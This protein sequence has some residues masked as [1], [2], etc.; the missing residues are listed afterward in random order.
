MRMVVPTSLSAQQ[1][2]RGLITNTTSSKGT[3]RFVKDVTAPALSHRYLLATSLAL[4]AVCSALAHARDLLQELRRLHDFLQHRVYLQWIRGHLSTCWPSLQQR[5]NQ[6][7]S[8]HAHKP[9][10]ARPAVPSACPEHYPGLVL[11]SPRFRCL[12]GSRE[13]CRHGIAHTC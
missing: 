13:V 9:L 2:L 8:T 7:Q 10:R 12:S 1:T 11:A 5:P 6:G 4:A 3:R